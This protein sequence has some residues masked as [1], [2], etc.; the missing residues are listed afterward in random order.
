MINGAVVRDLG[1][2]LAYLWWSLT[3]DPS[4]QPDI[5][6]KDFMLQHNIFSG[7]PWNE[8]VILDTT[9]EHYVVEEGGT[10]IEVR[11]LRSPDGKKITGD[12]TIGKRNGRCAVITFDYSGKK[13]VID[14]L[15]LY[16]GKGD[17][18][19]IKTYGLRS[20]SSYFFY[21]TKGGAE[22]P[23]RKQTKSLYEAV[24]ELLGENLPKNNLQKLSQNKGD[25]DAEGQPRTIKDASR[26]NYQE[27]QLL[28][29]YKNRKKYVGQKRGNI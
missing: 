10:K 24:K 1:K 18:T 2:V 12:M 22:W 16:P 5:Y 7:R 20:D 15:E 14:G 25:E 8:H 9:H 29:N 23:V 13:P 28:E 21:F 27:S 17:T 19:V 6:L 4:N 26:K 3:S 11:Y